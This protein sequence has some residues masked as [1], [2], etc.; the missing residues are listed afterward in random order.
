MK[1]NVGVKHEY[2]EIK[3]S[4]VKKLSQLDVTDL[5]GKDIKRDVEPTP[6]GLKYLGEYIERVGTGSTITLFRTQS[7][8]NC[9]NNI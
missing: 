7:K 2:C 3:E 4:C 6:S 1:S 5:S 9:T 8:G